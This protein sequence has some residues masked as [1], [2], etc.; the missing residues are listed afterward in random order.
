MKSIHI[1]IADDQPLVRIGLSAFIKTLNK[2]FII[3]EASSGKETLEIFYRHPIDL[4]ILDYRM[5]G[6]NGYEV[7][8]EILSVN[9][10]KKILIVSMFTDIPVIT[11]MFHIGVNG[12]ISKSAPIEEIEK[13][14]EAILSGKFYFSKEFE[15][16]I[17]GRLGQIPA[18]RFTERE[19]DLVI[20]LSKGKTSS[21]IAKNWGI[22]AKSVETYR[23]RLIEKTG[24]KNIAELIDYFH[25]N[26]Q[27]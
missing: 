4:L 9:I 3:H 21:E 22:S 6:L 16:L 14:I 13:A 5:P 1:L 27:L 8:R 2:N 17:P 12:I 20:N 24:V 15:A 10:T 23:S 26:G 18:I 11:N 19:L 7:A 25:R